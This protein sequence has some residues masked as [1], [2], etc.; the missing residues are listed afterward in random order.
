M[1]VYPKDDTFQEFA[2]HYGERLASY[3]RHRPWAT[4]ND[5]TT[6][7][8]DIA[9]TV[10]DPHGGYSTSYRVVSFKSQ[11]DTGATASMGAVL[12]RQAYLTDCKASLTFRSLLVSGTQHPTAIYY[13]FR[14]AAVCV[15]SNGGS[16][17]DTTGQQSIYDTNG[18][19]MVLA[20]NPALGGNQKWKWLLL[21]VNSGNITVLATKDAFGAVSQ[22]FNGAHQIQLE[23]TN[24]SGDV[25]LQG[26]YDGATVFAAA[27]HLD[28]QPGRITTAGRCGFG[29]C[30]DMQLTSPTR[31][32]ATIASRFSIFDISTGTQLL[33]DDFTRQTVA[34]NPL[35]T[36]GNGVSGKVMM[37]MWTLDIHGPTAW[38]GGSTQ[39]RDP[40]LNR[41]DVRGGTFNFSQIPSANPYTQARSVVFR[42]TANETGLVSTGVML[43]SNFLSAGGL[44]NGYIF[45]IDYVNTA[46]YARL[47]R[48]NSS[49]ET[50]LAVADVSTGYGLALGVDYTLLGSVRSSGAV[51]ST[52][53]PLLVM[54]INGTAVA[55]WGFLAPGVTTNFSQVFD[56][57]PSAILQGS[58]QGIYLVP[59]TGSNRVYYKLWTDEVPPDVGGGDGEDEPSIFLG[60]EC[61]GKVGA[62]TLPIA[63]D[64][65]V[66]IDSR[67]VAQRYE[68]G[69][70]TRVLFDRVTRRRWRVNLGDK[71]NAFLETFWDFW[72]AHGKSIPF[73]FTDPETGEVVCAHFLEDRQTTERLAPGVGVFTCVI[74]QLFDNATFESV[75][76]EGTGEVGPGQVP[77]V[78]VSLV[79]QPGMI[80]LIGYPVT[81][82]I[83]TPGSGEIL[84]TG[85]APLLTVK[86]FPGSGSLTLTG[87]APTI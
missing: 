55:G 38:T 30:R 73:D 34:C 24:V 56:G 81:L 31:G 74:E 33:S 13:D 49:V 45:R 5:T 82:N 86:L 20:N 58:A 44:Q 46:W 47:A 40:S 59:P 62:F 32:V 78:T 72:D 75:V 71:R 25:L 10:G 28:D 57:S 79:P 17:V 77:G 42:K 16:Y 27:G 29:M 66:E 15:R 87:Y 85:F 64:F 69:H 36:D 48:Y 50:V 65:E 4:D 67:V 14:F 11:S 18:Y 2:T 54:T 84:L 43:R 41:I 9:N 35:V 39:Y 37:S 7:G 19:W 83:L 53:T 61:E 8:Y 21:R 22:T 51:E 70:V 3:I 60:S 76:D 80:E 26:Y 63:V 68:T 6:T 23:A 1:G 12:W 52:G